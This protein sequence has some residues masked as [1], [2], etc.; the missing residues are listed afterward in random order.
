MTTKNPYDENETC[1]GCGLDA[2]ECICNPPADCCE[3]GSR[4]PCHVHDPSKLFIDHSEHV[5]AWLQHN[6][7][8]CS[9]D[10][11]GCEHSDWCPK[12]DPNE[13][14]PDL[15]GSGGRSAGAGLYEPFDWELGE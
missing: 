7:C 5:F 13:Y 11:M 14:D 2:S 6:A 3:H 4:C 8:T 9:G 1:D 15:D 12:Y 10:E